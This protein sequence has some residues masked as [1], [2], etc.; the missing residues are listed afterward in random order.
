M[1]RFITTQTKTN[2]VLGESV[3]QLNSKFE[4]TT[5]HQKM[6]ENQIAQIAQQVSHLSR[7]QGHLPG[8]PETNPKGQINTI[9]LR[10]GKELDGPPTPIREDKREIEDKGSARK[11]VPIE[12]PNERA[13]IEKPKEVEVESTSSPVKLYKPLV[14]YP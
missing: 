12:A 2:E 10:S 13:Q 8:Q 11:Q 1:E 9:T 5:T 4:A 7:R 14:P 6:M 3:S